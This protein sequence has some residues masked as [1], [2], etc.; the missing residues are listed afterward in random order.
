VTRS[1]PECR[2]TLWRG[3]AGC[4]L[5]NG[6]VELTHLTGGGQIP[7]F[8]FRDLP[9]SNP[10]WVPR[11][12][13]R[14][15][16]EFRASRDSARYG[17]PE[18]GRL[19]GAIAGHSLCLGTF[20]MPSDEEVR[21]GAV[22]HGE[23]GVLPWKSIL[24]RHEHSA[25]IRLSVRLPRAGFAFSRSVSL[26]RDE[27]VVRVRETVKN[28]LGVDQFLQ[29]QQ[30][31]ALSPSFLVPQH[32]FVALPGHRGI[33]DPGGYEGHELLA[34][35]REFV[36]PNAP[37]VAGGHRD[38]RRPFTCSGTGFVAGVEVDQRREYGFISAVNRALS[39]AFGCLFLRA[40]FPWVT[41]WEE[42]LA[43]K[44]SPWNAAEQVRAL[45]FGAS[46]L[47]TGRGEMVR[48]G[49]LFDLPTL[50]R[51]PAGGQLNA[52][53][54]MFLARL[55]RNCQDV[56]DVAC[57]ENSIQL[58]STDDAQIANL[59]AKG[60]RRLLQRRQSRRAGPIVGPGV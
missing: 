53:Y 47:P 8:R 10:L 58:L 4:F 22:L 56:D 17:S 14:E 23:A 33:T 31:V 28:L 59:A 21:A 48:R 7:E 54:C 55:P 9:E 60:V 34:R 37:G 42:N 6:I 19:L 3:R 43:R 24:V 41:V 1:V 32:A 18:V 45:E 26:R 36:W 40:D 16:F 5:A 11:W 57:G 12:E 13:L 49:N 46:P 50:V 30:H 44:A 29:W 20:G 2:S 25:E 15:P 35:N 27:S 39:I 38:L 52:S 51:L